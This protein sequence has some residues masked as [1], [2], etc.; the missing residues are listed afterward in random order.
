[1]NVRLYVVWGTLGVCLGAFLLLVSRSC[2]RAEEKKIVVLGGSASPA[3]ERVYD[4]FTQA[5]AES[6]RGARILSRFCLFNVSDKIQIAAMCEAALAWNPDVIVAAGA[7]AAQNIWS[8]MRTRKI[9]KPIICVGVVTAVELGLMHSFEH[10]GGH[11]TGVVGVAQDPIPVL[12][13]VIYAAKPTVKKILAPYNTLGATVNTVIEMIQGMRQFFEPRGIVVEELP[14]SDVADVLQKVE[15]RLSE[16]DMLVGIEYDSL[17]H[18]F[19][20]GYAKLCEQLGVTYFCTTI[21][22][23]QEGAAIT[24]AIDTAPMGAVAVAMAEQILF[25]GAQ[26]GEMP[27]ASAGDRRSLYINLEG[28]L[29]QGYVADIEHIREKLSYYPEVA[30]LRDRIVIVSAE[31]K[32]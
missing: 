7:T 18:H 14:L 2:K 5:L 21:G 20:S 27:V 12:A 25:A 15:C 13:P 4:R 17:V 29:H 16:C 22:G 19:S 8:L 1:M 30:W 28:A 3:F 23:V 26:V 10:P 32:E 11:V 24:Y 9:V 31:A 6:E